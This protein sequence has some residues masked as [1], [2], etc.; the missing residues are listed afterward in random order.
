MTGVAVGLLA[1]GESLPT[2]QQGRSMRLL[3]WLCIAV[4]V[5]MLAN[6][7][8]EPQWRAVLAVLPAPV[9]KQASCCTSQHSLAHI[10]LVQKQQSTC[11]TMLVLCRRVSGIQEHCVWCIAAHSS[12]QVTT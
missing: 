2:T 1:L 8:G 9:V 5:A 4:G 3:A 12:Q 6:G 11:M 7:Q 10:V